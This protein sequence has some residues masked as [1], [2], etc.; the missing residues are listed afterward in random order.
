M[1]YAKL[2]IL[3]FLIII[4][5]ICKQSSFPES[6]LQIQN[7]TNLPFTVI[8]LRKSSYTVCVRQ[9]AGALYDGPIALQCR[10]KILPGSQ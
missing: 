5:G 1:F 6:P 10:V 3:N 8:G 7:F 9:L 4:I 2:I